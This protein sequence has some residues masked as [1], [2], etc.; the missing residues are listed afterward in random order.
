MSKCAPVYSNG[1]PVDGFCYVVP[2]DGIGDSSQVEVCPDDEPQ[3][4]RFVG[5]G[6]PVLESE[7]YI[8]CVTTKYHPPSAECAEN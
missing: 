7:V 4:L 6:V 5:A 8:M 3:M 1:D 2:N